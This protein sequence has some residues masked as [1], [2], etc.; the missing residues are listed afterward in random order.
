M[1]T[2]CFQNFIQ[3]SIKG[4]IFDRNNIEFQLKANIFTTFKDDRKL[5]VKEVT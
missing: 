4:T 2:F 1:K 5:H 3:F